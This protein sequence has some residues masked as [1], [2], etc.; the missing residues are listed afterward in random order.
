MDKVLRSM[1]TTVVR[2]RASCLLCLPSWAFK[3]LVKWFVHHSA[4]ING[5]PWNIL[6]PSNISNNLVYLHHA[7]KAKLKSGSIYFV[8][9]IYEVIYLKMIKT[10][11]NTMNFTMNFTMSYNI[12]PFSHTFNVQNIWFGKRSES[13]K[14]SDKPNLISTNERGDN[15]RPMRRGDYF[16]IFWSCL[17]PAVFTGSF[18][19]PLYFIELHCC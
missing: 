9:N 19:F 17:R 8:Y 6:S 4:V 3:V 1:N 11:F 13:L 12:A 2:V 18:S 14:A 16:S 5:T 15:I 10:W 7:K